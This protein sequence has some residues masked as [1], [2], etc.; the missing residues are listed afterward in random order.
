MSGW[1]IEFQGLDELIKV[2]EKFSAE[3]E[4]D[5][6]NKNILKNCGDLAYTTVKPLI[7]RSKD[8]SKSGRRGSRP[9]EHAADNVPSPKFRKKNNRQIIII[10]WEKTD[11][12]PYYYMK[13]EE[14]GTSQRPPHHSFGLVNKKLSKEYDKIA[15]KEYEK[16]IKELE[17]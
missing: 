12:S 13:M 1:E 10:G 6:A 16:L 3:S 7:H 5:K 14:W 2:V 9:Q 4:I 8:N 17:K 11:T 15:L